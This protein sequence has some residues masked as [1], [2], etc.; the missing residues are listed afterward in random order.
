MFSLQLLIMQN[1]RSKST[2]VVPVTGGGLPVAAGARLP[3][4]DSRRAAGDRPPK[5][6]VVP[7]RVAL[8]L[9]V[10]CA[11]ALMLV[12]RLVAVASVSGEPRVH[13]VQSGETLWGL[14][15]QNTAE[16]DPRDYVDRLREVNRLSTPQIFPGQRL[17]LP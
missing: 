9:V 4:S 7:G 2:T 17:L 10:L 12:P 5:L 6:R 16:G 15:A 1:V 11:A 13:V 8:L 14:A 3:A